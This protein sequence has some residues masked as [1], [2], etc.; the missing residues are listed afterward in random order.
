VKKTG[1]AATSLVLGILSVVTLGC[2]G[3]GAVAAIG[4]GAL[5]LKKAK[6]APAV[7]G[8]RGMALGGIASGGL[9]LLAGVL[10]GTMFIHSL[11]HAKIDANESAAI[12]DIRAVIAAQAAYHR[13]SGGH[14]GRLECLADP[15]SCIPSYSGPALLDHALASATLR[16]NYRRAFHPGPAAA[17][18]GGGAAPSPSSLTSYAYVAVPMEPGKSGERGFC[19]D[20]TGMVCATEDSRQPEVVS[21]ACVVGRGCTPIR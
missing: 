4:C 1:L 20:S 19:G 9:S 21:G 2:L 17:T 6:A 16:S 15:P 5:A 10:A 14:Y 13:A 11:L 18:A 8:G 7:Y 12:G 3:V